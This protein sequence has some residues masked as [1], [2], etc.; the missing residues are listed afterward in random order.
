MSEPRKTFT[1]FGDVIG[2]VSESFHDVYYNKAG[3]IKKAEALA[4]L[5]DKMIRIWNI[6][7]IEQQQAAQYAMMRAEQN[8]DEAQ[9]SN[10]IVPGR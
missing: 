1:S 4:D 8:A 2:A 6:N 9:E 5:A 3:A 10:I 7:N